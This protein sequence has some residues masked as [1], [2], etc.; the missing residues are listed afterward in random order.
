MYYLLINSK[1]NN[2]IFIFQDRTVLNYPKDK[3]GKIIIIM[4]IRKKWKIIVNKLVYSFKKNLQFL[5]YTI[6]IYH[7][8]CQKV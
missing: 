2:Q 8:E 3:N 7:L 4:V 5:H 6:G 1:Y